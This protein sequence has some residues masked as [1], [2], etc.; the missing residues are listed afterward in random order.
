[1]RVSS[2]ELSRCVEEILVKLG[3]SRENAQTASAYM[4]YND[5]RGV[6]T[7]G[8]YL[9]KAIESRVTAGQLTLPT[10]VSVL[11]DQCAAVHLDGNDG[12][13]MVAADRG[14]RIAAERAKRYGISIVL[15]RNT[16]NVGSLAS[17]TTRLADEGFIGVMCC[18]AAPAVAPW[19]GAEAILGTNPIGISIP[20]GDCHLTADMATSVVA[21]GKIRRAERLGEPIPIGWALDAQGRPTTDPGAALA[22]TL[23]PFG[24]PKGSALSFTVDIVAGLLSGS[25]CG[26]DV[27]SFHVNEGPT[28]V[29][30]AIAA[31]DISKFMPMDAFDARMLAYI[32]AAKSIRPAEGYSEILMPGEPEERRLRSSDAMGGTEVDAGQLATINALA[33][34]YGVTPIA[35]D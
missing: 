19:G 25:A 12:V 1:M 20:G 11:S 2:S 9:I 6:P 31:I 4:L 5:R 33:D 16:N 22:G 7:H 29:G 18:N 27:R 32:S 3:E 34:R 30:V 14:V 28:G 13:G 26:S 17:Y 21:R 8:C 24:G 23:L 15:I 35:A 10:Q